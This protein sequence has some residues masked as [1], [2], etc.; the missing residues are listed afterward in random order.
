MRTQRFSDR[1]LVEFK[2]WAGF[3]TRTTLQNW[4]GWYDK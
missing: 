3:S 4:S 1:K 2:N